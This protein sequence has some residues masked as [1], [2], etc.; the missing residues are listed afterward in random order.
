[1]TKFKYL[2]TAATNQL[3][4][5]RNYGRLHS[6]IASYCLVQ[7]LSSFPLP[8]KIA[9]IKTYKAN[10]LYAILFGFFHTFTLREEQWLIVFESRMPWILDL[11]ER[12]KWDA[13]ER[14]L[15]RSLITCTS[16]NNIKV[17]KSRRMRCRW[18]EGFTVTVC[19]EVFLGNQTCQCG[20]NIWHF[21]DNFL[22]GQLHTEESDRLRRL[23]WGWSG[24]DM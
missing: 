18:F 17:M 16:T 15:I 13:A 5:W 14:W 2:G 6:G 11:R 9:E 4:S 19:S 22:N 23:Q 8:F 3:H 7:N 12:K 1:V 20:I 24:F 21:R 10:I